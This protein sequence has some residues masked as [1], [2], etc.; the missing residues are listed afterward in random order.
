MAEPGLRRTGGAYVG[1]YTPWQTRVNT[2]ADM[3]QPAE[4]IGL[5]LG[6]GEWRRDG[7]VAWKHFGTKGHSC[8]ERRGAC[9]SVPFVPILSF[10]N[11]CHETLAASSS[12]LIPRQLVESFVISIFN[13]Q[14]C[15]F[16]SKSARYCL[17]FN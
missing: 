10:R 13:N 12:S 2:L 3:R 4:H 15:V 17:T 8:R 14:R 16:E 7:G 6:V 1:T 5:G 9:V 11:N